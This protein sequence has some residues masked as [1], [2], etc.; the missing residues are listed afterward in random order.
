MAE[1]GDDSERTE[2][3]SQKRLE[4]A[5]RRG[6]VVKSQEVNTWFVMAGATLVLM[7]F[8]AGMSRDLGATLRGI[9]ANSWQ[10][11]VDGPALPALFRKLGGEIVAAVA[12]PFLL[13]MLAALAGNLVQHKLVWS[14]DTLMPKLSKIS[15]SAGLKR[16]FSKQA[17]A[18]FAKGLIKLVLVSAVLAALMW[19]ER[20]R[21][22]ALVRLDPVALMPF[23]A[24]LALKLMGTVIAMLAAVAAGDYLFQYRQWYDKQK[25]SLR[26]LKEEFRQ[27]EGDPAVKGKL[28]QMR[29]AR[30]RKRMIAA[31]PKASVVITNPTHFAVALQ[32]ERGMAAPVCVAKGVDRL[33]LKIREIAAE[34]RIPVVENPP[35]ARALH[36]TVEVDE[37]I[38]PEHYK[39]VAE[40]IGYV[41]RLRRAV[42]AR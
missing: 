32:Y 40:V 42:A 9:I 34:H 24:E 4:E 30:M 18:N 19:P 11:D 8:S 15:P 38:P 31:V 14:F 1:A 27:S 28:K 26:E 37:V 20:E 23:V 17:L 41:M 21:M 35:L 3:P 12:I 5:L 25:M 36:A 13:L 22:E 29:Q 33:A 2:E 7:A 10:I 16:Q 6:D 39:A